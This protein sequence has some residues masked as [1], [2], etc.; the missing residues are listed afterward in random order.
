M[1]DPDPNLRAQA[2]ASGNPSRRR[3]L[4]AVGFGA[5]AL[6]IVWLTLDAPG[7]VWDETIYMGFAR[8]YIDW[9]Q[10]W[11]RGAFTTETIE[12]AWGKG[13]VHPPL[14]KLGLALGIK[15]FHPTFPNCP[16]LDV[17]AI[18]LA[19][20]C[21]F[22]LLTGMAFWW[23]ATAF[24]ECAGALSSL[25]M[26]LMPRLFG[27]AHFGTLDMPMTALWF[28]AVALFSQ[29]GRSRGWVWAAAIALG[30]AG[31]T[32]INAA[33]IPLVLAPYAVWRLRRKAV[34]PLVILAVVPLVM[35]L[36][37]WPHLWVD[38][39]QHLRQYVTDKASRMH[40]EAYYGGRAFT[41]SSPPWHYPLVLTLATVPVPFLAAAAFASIRGLKRRD[42]AIVLLVANAALVL[43]V[44]CLAFVPKYDG[45]RLFLPA[46]PFVACLA[47]VG[48]SAFV[49]WLRS[50]MPRRAWLAWLVGLCV[51][52][53]PAAEVVHLHP[54]QLSYYNEAV[55]FLSGAEALGFEPT[56]W[57]DTLASETVG[58]L[59]R[60]C[61]PGEKVAFFPVGSYVP[62]THQNVTKDLRPD[63][64]IVD[65]ESG[66]WRWLVLVSRYGKFDELAWAT[67]RRQEPVFSVKRW[68]VELCSVYRK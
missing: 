45:V 12:W 46:F 65:Y 16:E 28:V 25:A 2:A 33:F 32:K 37:L 42:P 51:L 49:G 55:G 23:M 59:N 6:L 36:A 17:R 62:S 52:A 3:L 68:G 44:A 43:G 29:V 56:Y 66:Q 41:D 35:F 50:R 11:G 67:H 26:I 18:R 8:R 38:T 14:G 63:V 54:F 20:A 61:V 24:G 27:H 9:F 34:V 64:Q 47:G 4:H 48:L 19:S 57:G 15:L 53:S 39:W 13:Q 31:L 58:F 21:W 30:A 60:T 7:L 40:V 22:A 1:V 10:H 5:L